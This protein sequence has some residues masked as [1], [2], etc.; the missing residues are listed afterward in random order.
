MEAKVIEL[1]RS[2]RELL[3]GE[4]NRIGDM[5]TKTIDARRRIYHRSDE[6]LDSLTKTEDELRDKERR[7]LLAINSC[8]DVLHLLGVEVEMF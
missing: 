2:S 6:E 1:V 7:I 8:K 5:L 3:I 4:Y